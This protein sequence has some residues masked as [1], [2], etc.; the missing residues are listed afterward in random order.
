MD[1][2]QRFA[3]NFGL[4]TFSFQAYLVSIMRKDMDSIP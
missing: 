1:L 4:V 2:F 3:P